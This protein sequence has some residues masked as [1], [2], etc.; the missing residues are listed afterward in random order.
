MYLVSLKSLLVFAM[1][2]V[3]DEE[4]PQADFRGINVGIE[5]PVEKQGYPGIWVDYSDTAP[6]RQAG[7]SHK[8]VDD[9]GLP[10]WA[11]RFKFEG[12]VSFTLVALSSLERDRLY[13]EIIRV[14]AFGAEDGATSQF[15]AI[16]EDN[17]LIAVNAKFDEIEVGGNAAAP[18][19]PWGTDE[20]I[21]EKTI[22]LDLI[23]EFLADPVA[24]NMV[25]LSGFL[26]TALMDTEIGSDIE[27]VVPAG[28]G[29]GAWI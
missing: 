8:E 15:R 16:I 2:E 24:G 5:Y 1:R 17:D 23:G 19:T 4:F 28:D 14:F 25:P 3:F 21:Y 10:T 18:G 27:P 12:T 11:T 22:S 26:V 7:V 29:K 6:L 9:D 20:I 13:D